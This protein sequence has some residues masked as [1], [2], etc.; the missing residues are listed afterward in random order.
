MTKLSRWF[1]AAT[2]CAQ[3]SSG[4]QSIP[5]VTMQA[6]VDAP[7]PQGFVPVGNP[8][9]L[10]PENLRF[11]EPVEIRIPYDPARVRN[12][13]LLA[14]VRLYTADATERVWR[15]VDGVT[16][17]PTA[18]VLVAHVKH[19]S[20][21]QAGIADCIPRLLYNRDVSGPGPGPN[22]EHVW[23]LRNASRCPGNGYFVGDPEVFRNIGGRWVR[24]EPAAP[25]ITAQ[26][27]FVFFPPGVVF[28]S[29]TFAE[30]GFFF[31]P[32]DAGEFR[33]Y[34]DI[35]RP[36]GA[37][38]ERAPIPRL[39]G[40]LP[41]ECR[42]YTEI[43]IRLARPVLEG[44]CDGIVTDS[45]TPRLQWF[46]VADATRYRV[47]LAESPDV[48]NALDND[49]QLCSDCIINDTTADSFYDVPGDRLQGSHE[50]FWMVRAGNA[51][52]G[53]PNSAICSFRTPA[54]PPDS[55]SIRV[56]EP[57]VDIAVEPGAE[58]RIAW[59]GDSPGRPATVSLGYDNN[60]V[61]GD[62]YTTIATGLG[63]VG[64]YP[65]DTTGVPD[66]TYRI[67]GI[68]E[69][70]RE[71]NYD[72][73][74]GA[75][76]IGTDPALCEDD[77]PPDID[78]VD[79][80]Q[81][82][83]GRAFFRVRA[84][85]NTEPLTVETDFAGLRRALDVQGGDIY[86][87]MFQHNE[88]ASVT[89]SVTATD[90]CGNTT[91]W[92]PVRL[93]SSVS[94]DLG[95]G[96]CKDNKNTCKRGGSQGC[97]GDPV[98][99]FSGNFVRRELDA[100][101]PGVGDTTLKLERVYDHLGAAWRPASFARF[102][103]GGASMQVLVAP[104]QPFGRG[105][106]FPYSM[107]LLNIAQAPYF[108][109]V[110][111]QYADGRTVLFRRE[112]GGFVSESPDVHDILEQI[113]SDYVLKRTCC[114][115]EAMRF[116]AD[117]L[118]TE[119]SDRNGNMVTLTY[120]GNRAI[121]I[122]NASGRAA[123][124]SYDGSDHVT[125]IALPEGIILRYEYTG[126]LLTAFVDGRGMRT[127]YRYDANGFLT[128]I[129]TPK[130][131]PSVRVQYDPTTWRAVR[132]V[133]GEAESLTFSYD[134]PAGTTS[135]TDAYG[136]ARVH[137]YDAQHRLVRLDYPDGTS[138]AFGYD[139]DFNRT[140]HRDQS[141]AEW[142]WTYDDRGNRLTADG[143]LGWRR[144]WTY[145]EFDLPTSLVERIDVDTS[146]LT[147]FAYD[148]AGNLIEVC[149]AL[150]DCSNTEYDDRGLPIVAS[151]FSGNVTLHSYD[152]HGDRVSSTDP[153]SNT[154]R[155]RY[156]GLG[157][158]VRVQTPTGAAYDYG[159]DAASNVVSI[160]G[161]LGFHLG[162]GFDPN[163][164]QSST[165]DPNGGLTQ[166]RHDA[167]E[168]LVEV[169]GP[170]GF[171][172][173]T[174]SYGLMNERVGFEDAEGRRT[175]FEHDALLRVSHAAGPLGTHAYFGYD[176]NGRLVDLTDLEGIVAHTEYDALSRPVGVVRNYQPGGGRTSDTNVT[177]TLS[178]DLVGNLLQ[179][180]DPAGNPTD[181]ED[182]LLDRR[183][184]ATDAEGNA[185]RYGYD[186]VGNLVR[187]TN[188][189]GFVTELVYTPNH[190]L[191]H[192]VDAQGN[193]TSYSHDAE[194]RLIDEVD[195]LGVVTRHDYD[196]LGRLVRRTR[197]YQAGLPGDSQT[198]V[199][200][201][202]AYDPAGNLRFITSPRGD[203]SELQYDAAHRN[204]RA[205]D[206]EGGDTAFAYDRVD[207]LLAVTDDNAHVTSFAY[208]ALDRRVSITNAE[209]HT[210]DFSYDRVGS[211]TAVTDA[212][213]NLS[214]FARDPLRRVTVKTDALR[215][216]WRFSYDPVGN[217]TA[218]EDANGH[219]TR[220]LYDAIYRLVSATAPE[221]NTLEQH[222]DPNSNLAGIVD[223]IGNPTTFTYDELDRVT[224]LTNAEGEVRSFAYNPL[225]RQTHEV[226]ADGTV[227]LFSYDPLYRL[228][229]VTENHRPAEAPSSDT[230]V[231]TRYG[232]DPDGNLIETTNP[233]GAVTRFDYDGMNRV[234]RET[235][236]LER[237]TSYAYDGVGNRVERTDGNGA[238]TRYAFF[239]D[240]QVRR[241]DYFDGTS[242]DFAYDPNN[243]RVVM[244]DR[245]GTT[246]WTYDALDRVTAAT[247]PFARQIR[248][249]YDAV[250]NRTQVTY[251]DGSLV[252]Y[253][254]SANDWLASVVDPLGGVTSYERD[255]VG[256]VTRTSNPNSTVS[257]YMYDRVYRTLTLANRQI[258]GAA[259]VNSSF[260][261]TYNAVG[262][263]TQVAKH[264]GW[265]IPA[266]EVETYG[267]DGLHR[268]TRA[269]IGPR[270]RADV[271]MSYVY[272]AAGN[273]LS[274]ASTDDLATQTPGDGFDRSY[275]YDAAN[276]VL[277]VAATGGET[278]T[279]AYD[280][281]GNRIGREEDD[282]IGPVQGADYTYDPE[283]RLTQVLDYQRV[284]R[285]SRNRIDRARTDLGYDGGG[286]RLVQ[287][288][289]P[290]SGDGGS[291]R[292]EY[293]FDGLDPVAEYDLLNGQRDQFYRGDENRLL[294]MH[295]LPAGT[296]G[297]VLWYAHDRKGD[298]VGLTK[299]SGQSSHNYRYDPYG[300]VLPDTGNFTD[301]H[302][303]YTLT[304]KE[305][306]ENTG[307]VWF[308]ARHYD[309]RSGVWLTQDMY[310][311]ST[312]QPATLHRTLYV[313]SSPANYLDSYG[314]AA[315]PVEASTTL[316]W[317]SDGLEEG[318]TIDGTPI[319]GGGLMVAGAAPPIETFAVDTTWAL[320][321]CVAANALSFD[322]PV[323]SADD[324]NRRFR[325]AA[326]SRLVASR[327]VPSADDFNRRFRE[328]FD[329]GYWYRNTQPGIRARDA[330]LT[331]ANRSGVRIDP[332]LLNEVRNEQQRILAAT[333]FFERATDVTYATGDFLTFDQFSPAFDSAEEA[334]QRLAR[335]GVNA[336]SV[337]NLLWSVASGTAR[338]GGAAFIN[339]ALAGI[340]EQPSTVAAR[341]AQRL[342]PAARTFADGQLEK[343]FAKH[344]A[345]WGAGNITQARYLRRA[346][347]LLSRQV[348]GDILGATR[349]GGDILRYNVRTNEFAVGT[350]EGAIRTL[351]RPQ[352]GMAYW[353]RQIQ[354]AL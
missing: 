289:D 129:V 183:I 351:F 283:N 251:P 345:E 38:G 292:V 152:V 143:P 210:T 192:L 310:R 145:N 198:N 26:P 228:A 16:V 176:A 278:T 196:L 118:L 92:G 54:P 343:H 291:K 124:L 159:Y 173:A 103:G 245:L 205:I 293:L 48:L 297:Q 116:N 240:D 350:A 67:V 195:A 309:P 25:T 46:R 258:G 162:F 51:S 31:A 153:E 57:S 307:L 270:H 347:D 20:F 282:G 316:Y 288:Y 180:I 287:T 311:G 253:G 170:L 15:E 135:V 156:D 308:G 88:R 326:T 219:A 59:E 122:R 147:T 70:D 82:G 194:G 63:M 60:G 167:S 209:G 323:P 175:T 21:F 274:W 98:N 164:N 95:D 296:P 12:E 252:Q 341:S 119:I 71:S 169:V 130:G 335:E 33:I 136:H 150:R 235:D 273:R 286:R 111:I 109:G 217:V 29:T 250:G 211:V 93:A 53:S 6:A 133:L 269:E 127:E 178:Y 84:T 330:L 246:S 91:T 221:G 331:E 189:R 321:L 66:G 19:F 314:E 146:R 328:W 267:Y 354:R 214:A 96:K 99:T 238:L 324:I 157:R 263:V 65:W 144:E 74:P 32:P 349:S 300:A 107:F 262:H 232:Y 43:T 313:A 141:G 110:Q 68:I 79:A 339:G 244:N 126:D 134:V 3:F 11:A 23:E 179:T 181:Y 301:P 52:G 13:A 55:P 277:S 35:L 265:R 213:G 295:H 139:D 174:Y 261:Y 236:P 14:N 137:H 117:G 131:H 85:D 188:P 237:V 155:F 203:E 184:S 255:L 290:N 249:G 125:E 2:I 241:I 18:H 327:E 104:P 128:E 161:P 333:R 317:P 78:S 191:D 138:E 340:G 158:R 40:D 242:V 120:D 247:D 37:P 75:V 353:L 338:V 204:I 62:G 8:W 113:G 248:Y 187:Q 100:V 89:Y 132:Q 312:R 142:R 275:E 285:N 227:K 271:V 149:D 112:G 344:A 266:E 160:D 215:G 123:A 233:L 199:M 229:A 276:E 336:G 280:R 148:E 231:V 61:F 114:S 208:D 302:N 239:P 190:W 45:L 87:T 97:D 329:R 105:W 5:G 207:N 1:L 218:A 337:G 193:V 281:N 154:T 30:V 185:H 83:E 168:N 41:G 243:N 200:T 9:R 24:Y 166:Y 115:L 49:D 259:E 4:C 260:E 28:G 305:F 224:T 76:T 206:F 108:D 254:Y 140:L 216:T 212:N 90:A 303:H 177:T 304:G 186:A 56:V 172:T 171:V 222:W 334:G 318:L 39:C 73:A 151:D 202:F 272:D 352:E 225:G 36:L 7:A 346:Q 80:W 342:L 279:F 197:N 86:T 264:Y 102:T 17:D 10:H 201:A 44:P 58:V 284:G 94:G 299:Q 163:G 298:V 106:V 234:V 320:D 226:E 64:A 319:M 165:T 81:S 322:G 34:F 257:E 306:D 42:L 223:P 121:E 325:S 315:A 256:H 294:A 47:F 22:Y 50:Y 348:G 77:P 69:N 72:Y 182:D 230:N 332:F 268:L 220:F 27:G 101:V